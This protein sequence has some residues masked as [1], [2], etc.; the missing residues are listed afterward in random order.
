MGEMEIFFTLEISI[1]L[2]MAQR[3]AQTGGAMGYPALRSG[4]SVQ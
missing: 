3:R 4:I 2:V 1:L